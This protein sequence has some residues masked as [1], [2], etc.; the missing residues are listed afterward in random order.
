MA[1]HSVAELRNVVL[2]GHG[3]AGKTS[4]ADLMLYKAGE[5]KKQ[6][7]PDDQTSVLDVDDDEK[8]LHHSLTSH[9][10][11]HKQPKQ[12]PVWC[13]L[14]TDQHRTGK[15]THC[16]SQDFRLLRRVCFQGFLA[17]AST[18]VAEKPTTGA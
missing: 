9:I 13:E 11:H 5:T 7:S 8:E 17:F 10:S 3:H 18:E 6:G 4:L 14:A 15:L 16:R 1:N 2:V 12:P